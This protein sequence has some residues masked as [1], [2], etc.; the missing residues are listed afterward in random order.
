[1]VVFGL[2]LE[3]DSSLTVGAFFNADLVPCQFLNWQLNC[4]F[5][6]RQMS[7][8][9]S[10]IYREDIHW[11]EDLVLLLTSLFAIG[12]AFLIIIGSKTC[13]S[14]VGFGFMPP[15]VGCVFIYF[16]YLNNILCCGVLQMIDRWYMGVNLIGIFIIF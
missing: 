3:C 10:Y 9:I 8:M 7:F 13:Y 11:W 4:L 12:G 2:T 5:F 14:L 6:T 16:S 15:T 1:L